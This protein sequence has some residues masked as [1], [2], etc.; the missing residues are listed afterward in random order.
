MITLHNLDRLVVFVTVVD[1]QSLTE[2]AEELLLTQPGVSQH[3][4][5]LEETYGVRLLERKRRPATPTE[6]GRTVYRFAKNILGLVE[7]LDHSISELRG[8]QVGKLHIGASTPIGSYLLPPILIRF[9]RQYPGAEIRLM[10]TTGDQIYQALQHGDIQLGLTY[11]AKIPDDLPA[12]ILCEEEMVLV[13]AP[14]HPLASQGTVTVRQLAEQSFIVAPEGTPEGEILAQAWRR[15]GLVPR[16]A[17]T[18]DHVEAAKRAVQEGTVVCLVPRVCVAH[19][20][21]AGDLAEL[22][23]RDVRFRGH[24]RIIHSPFYQSPLLQHFLS[25]LRSEVAM[26]FPE[27]QSAA[28][29]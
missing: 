1:K 25:F 2:A 13:V 17:L 12:E 24:Y 27:G 18:V 20:L 9:K 22:K 16:V 11:A 28:E 3:I 10:I 7:D 21:A 14:H 5:S 6:A 29:A 15:M 26:L 8:A 4:K 23:I 19:E